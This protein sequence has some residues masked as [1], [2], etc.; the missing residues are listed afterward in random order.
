[1][2]FLIFFHFLSFFFNNEEFAR[3]STPRRCPALGIASWTDFYFS[4][5]RK[6]S[7]FFPHYQAIFCTVLGSRVLCA[8]RVFISSFLPFL[9]LFSFPIRVSDAP[10]LGLTEISFGPSILLLVSFFSI[11][12]KL[13]A[14]F[15][16][17][18][19]YWF[20][21]NLEVWDFG[22]T[23]SWAHLKHEFPSLFFMR[24]CSTLRSTQSASNPTYTSSILLW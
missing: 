14:V 18:I 23:L 22:F 17:P 5:R 1:M 6:I 7:W 19:S 3:C 4:S 9:S 8:F 11:R 12:Y 24:V 20:H 10:R 21:I 15:C 13:K 2:R 16:L